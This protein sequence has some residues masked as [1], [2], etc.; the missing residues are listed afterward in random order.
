MSFADKFNLLNEFNILRL[1]CGLFMIPHIYGKF[2]VPAALGFF[3]AAEYALVSVRPTRVEEL[4]Q[5]GR[6]GARSV[7]LSLDRLDHFI[8]ATQLGVTVASLSLGWLGEPA[9]AGLLD[10]LLSL[11]PAA[12]VGAASHTLSAIMAFGSLPRTI[13]Y[14]WQR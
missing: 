8:A 4:L 7:K 3:V 12:W 11:L 5:Q 9:L 14:P 10:P 6:S 13:G 1:I 2:Y